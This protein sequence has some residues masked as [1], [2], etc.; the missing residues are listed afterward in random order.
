MKQL[1]I[2]GASGHGKVV[3]DIGKKCGYDRIVFLDDRET[4]TM[5]LEVGIRFLKDYLDGDLYF[6]TAYPDH[7]LDRARTQLKLVADM[8]SKWDE[9]NRIVTDVAKEIRSGN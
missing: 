4:L 1:V 5:T 7:N 2:I 8:H 6:K 3:A 9:M